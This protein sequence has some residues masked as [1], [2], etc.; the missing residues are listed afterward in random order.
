MQA[1]LQ[2]GRTVHDFL[3]WRRQ[4]AVAI[5]SY[6][7]PPSSPM[8]IPW[9]FYNIGVIVFSRHRRRAL[10]MAHRQKISRPRATPPMF[11][12]TTYGLQNGTARFSKISAHHRQ[13]QK[14]KAL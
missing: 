1:G 2:M 6:A 14:E 13:A 3:L 8:Q 10:R 5:A 12:K 7:S 9:K 4:N 11:F